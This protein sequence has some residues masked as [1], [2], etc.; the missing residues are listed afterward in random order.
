VA[1]R[2]PALSF[3][4]EAYVDNVTKI[5]LAWKYRSHLWRY[6]K[7]IR[8]RKQV[9]AILATGAGAAIA[10]LAYRSAPAI[11]EKLTA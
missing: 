4:Q 3:H 8:R 10:Y 5:R 6:R 2:L 1:E 7:L 9:A 11:R